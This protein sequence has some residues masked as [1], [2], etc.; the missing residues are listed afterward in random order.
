[1][2]MGMSKVLYLYYDGACHLCSREISHY[3]SLDSE[4]ILGL[5]D[6]SAPGFNP[7]NEGLL[8]KDF[9]KYM[10]AKKASGEIVVG[11]LAFQAIWDELGV[12]KLMS[13]VSKNKLGFILMNFVYHFFAG[14][15]PYLS[16]KQKTNC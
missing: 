5:I 11:V 10:H 1:M 9:N 3:K 8:D 2:G 16:K 15:R 14:I 12:M 6:I 4:N 13:R 7:E